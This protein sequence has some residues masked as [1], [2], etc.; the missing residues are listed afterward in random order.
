MVAH[1]PVSTSQAASALE[2]QEIAK[3]GQEGL[4]RSLVK[5]LAPL[6]IWKL[7]CDG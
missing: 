7:A 3:W 5:H 6:I 1:G 4:S 2:M